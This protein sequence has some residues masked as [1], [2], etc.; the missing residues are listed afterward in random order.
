MLAYRKRM[1]AVNQLP[2][3]E[4]EIKAKPSNGARLPLEKR[5]E[6]SG[7]NAGLRAKKTKCMKYQQTQKVSWQLINRNQE[8][9]PPR[10]EYW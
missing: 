3:A 8:A 7:D 9:V 1:A 6:A 2:Y 4:N 5:E 10:A